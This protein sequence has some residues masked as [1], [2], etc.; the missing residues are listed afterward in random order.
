MLR[1]SSSFQT[2]Q[3]RLGELRR[4]ADAL[5]T[6]LRRQATENETRVADLEA[7]IAVAERNRLDAVEQLKKTEDE[8]RVSEERWK[9]DN[10]KLQVCSRRPSQLT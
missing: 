8:R 4:Y 6:D 9:E 10:D 1:S 7:K 3:E 5:E 2:L